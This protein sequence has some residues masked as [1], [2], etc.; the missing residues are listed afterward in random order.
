MSRAESRAID[1]FGTFVQLDPRGAAT[2]LPVTE[3]FWT[4][5]IQTLTD[6]YLVTSFH[7]DS[8]WSSWEMHPNGDELIYVRTGA[9][10][11]L[12]EDSQGVQRVPVLAGQ[13]YVMRRGVWHR[14]LARE[15]ADM[16]FITSGEGTQ[17]RPA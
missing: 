2:T 4:Q 3:T 10:D 11:L 13:L 12:V 16:L 15:P 7:C 8:D 17:H 1:P 14:A 9:V 6:G 5:T